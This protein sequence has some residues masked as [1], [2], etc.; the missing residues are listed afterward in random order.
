MSFIL[1][2]IIGISVSGFILVGVISRIRKFFLVLN[3]RGILKLLSLA[4]LKESIEFLGSF[5]GFLEFSSIYM[6]DRLANLMSFTF[7]GLSS[8]SKLLK[9]GF[10]LREVIAG[11]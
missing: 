9:L 8:S 10:F 3:N 6:R 7:Y 5:K 1:V 2:I 11:P 4:F